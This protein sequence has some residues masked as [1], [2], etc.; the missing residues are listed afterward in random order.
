MKVRDILAFPFML[1]GFVFIWLGVNIGGK[2]TAEVILGFSNTMERKLED[3]I[4]T[5]N[6]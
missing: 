5:N 4:K 2:F 1:I 6:L 3:F